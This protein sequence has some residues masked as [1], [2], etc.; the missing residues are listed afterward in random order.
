MI[1]FIHRACITK[2]ENPKSM[3]ITKVQFTTTPLSKPIGPLDAL[4]FVL[5][6]GLAAWLVA[7]D[8]F[9]GFV[10]GAGGFAIIALVKTVA[11][12]RSAKL[13]F[14]RAKV[15]L[16]DNGFNPDLEFGHMFAMDSAS[17]KIAFMSLASMEY[18][19]YPAREILSCEHQ[20]T[21]TPSSNGQI[22]KKQNYL[23]FNT[24]NPHSPLYKFRTF[25]H[26]T[27]ELWLARVK[28][29]INS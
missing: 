13:S 16:K 4:L 9:T 26:A 21:S 10:F 18:E 28:A 5:L 6:P 19:I 23:V 11:R 12:Y 29:V 7:E 20:W 1:L 8:S 14:A 27:G 2:I 24:T 17:K 15:H 22:L 3:Q 25:D